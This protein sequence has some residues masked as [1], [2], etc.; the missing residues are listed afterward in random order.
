[1]AFSWTCQPNRKDVHAHIA[2]DFMNWRCVDCLKEI[3]NSRYITW[4]IQKLF[5][6]IR[7]YLSYL[8]I[9][10]LQ[11]HGKTASNV[12]T[13][14]V[15]GLIDGKTR[16]SNSCT[17]PPVFDPL[18][19]TSRPYTFEAALSMILYKVQKFGAQYAWH[20][21][22]LNGN[23]LANTWVERI[24]LVTKTVREISKLRL[25]AVN[26]R[27]MDRTIQLLRQ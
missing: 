25:P 12:N 21:P 5:S 8:T 15:V 3:G 14:V 13:K 11:M 22:R 7:P 4:M 18:F 17:R 26:D 6:P 19:P 23:S 27:R 1:M 9:N 16:W 24:N 10:N 2:I 20:R